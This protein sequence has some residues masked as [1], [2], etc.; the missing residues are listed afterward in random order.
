M[1]SKLGWFDSHPF[2]SI[3]VYTILI[4]GTVAGCCKFIIVDNTKLNYEAQL[5]T[6]DVLISQLETRIKFLENESARLESDLNQY[7]EWLRNTPGTLEYLIAEN[8]ALQ[9]KLSNQSDSITSKEPT[10]Q[11]TY[12]KNYNSIKANNSV[13]DE[14]SGIVI[15]LTDINSLYKGRLSIWSPGSELETISG[16]SSGFTKEISVGEEKYQVSITMID[17]ISNSYSVFICE[18]A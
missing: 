4:A 15:S 17:Y 3:V 13:I 2:K 1:K 10:I 6:K 5:A 9:T 12:S 14:K 18:L 8:E 11:S 16:V 7:E